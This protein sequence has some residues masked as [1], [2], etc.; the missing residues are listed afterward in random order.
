MKTENEINKEIERMLSSME[1]HG[2]NV[3]RQRELSDLMDRLAE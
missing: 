3:K 1:K 2:R